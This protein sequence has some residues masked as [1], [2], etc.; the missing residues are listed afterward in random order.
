[1]NKARA[2]ALLQNA[3]LTLEEEIG[4]AQSEVGLPQK[5]EAAPVIAS[6]EPA[7]VPPKAKNPSPRSPKASSGFVGA[8]RMR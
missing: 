1:V 5:S 6:D 7:E 3:I 2:I 8:L 4:D